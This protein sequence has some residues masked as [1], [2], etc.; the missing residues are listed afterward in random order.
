MVVVIKVVDQTR[1]AKI[2]T[3][4]MKIK[5]AKIYLSE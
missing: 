3:I 2:L 4:A 5:A 1:A